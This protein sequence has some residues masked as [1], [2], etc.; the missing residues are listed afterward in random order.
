[1]ITSLDQKIKDVLLNGKKVER[2]YICEKSFLYF[3]VYYF[4]EFFTYKIAPFHYQMYQDCHDLI[5][6]KINELAWIMFR[7]SAKTSIAKIF[8]VWCICYK[9]KE[10]INYD[11]YA[12]EN[13]EAALFDIAVWLQTNPKIVSDFGNLYYE[14]KRKDGLKESKLKRI[15]NFVTANGVKCEAFSTQEST[16]GR[17]YKHIRPDLFV[18]DDFETSKTKDSYPVTHK[19][20]EHI[21]EM[22]AG[23]GATGSI[24]YLGNYITEDG[25]IARILESKNE[26]L[27]VRNIPVV[28]NNEIMWKSKYVMTNEEAIG[29]NKVSL[30]AKRESLGDQVF[31]A[32]MMNNPA[33]TQ[34]LV[35]D[36]EIMDTLI[37][38][39]KSPIEEN[40]GL[41]MWKKYELGRRYGLGADTAEGIG[42]DSNATAVIDFSGQFADDPAEV[43]AT[44]ENNKIA[45][46]LFAYE[47]KRDCELYG[48]CIAGVELNNTGFATVTQLKQ[49]YDNIYKRERKDQQTDIVTKEL[50][51]KTTQKSKPDIIFQLKSAV[52][53]KELR[54]WD[55]DLLKEM[56]AYKQSD[57]ATMRIEEGMTRHFDKMIACAIAWEMRKSSQLE[58]K[59]GVKIIRTSNPRKRF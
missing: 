20:K 9:K 2:K 11:S 52:E 47:I 27:R 28:M 43:V 40:S 58:K 44:Y 29:T 39:A 23:L 54:I 49:I 30:E 12:K 32:E 19:I 46:D 35:F 3:A 31:E 24:I 7:E 10:Y 37:E 18:L 8:I 25:N 14:P 53:K 57:L 51:W 4:S 33:T 55:I 34:D 36:R 21:D 42:L 56:R 38:E 41:K 16:R 5:D 6:K 17:V 59:G 26:M 45:P 48:N 50:G 15:S 13:A 22:K 1:M